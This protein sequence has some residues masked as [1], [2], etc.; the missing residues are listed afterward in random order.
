MLR[1]LQAQS[2]GLEVSVSQIFL[3]TTQSR[4]GLKKI[5]EGPGLG[6]VMNGKPKCLISVLDLSFLFYKLIFNCRNSLKLVL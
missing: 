1:R 5:W 3:N 6:L 2:L 4:L